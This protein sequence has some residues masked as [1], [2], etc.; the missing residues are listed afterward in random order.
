MTIIALDSKGHE[1]FPEPQVQKQA[2]RV[3]RSAADKAQARLDRIEQQMIEAK[4]KV[5]LARLSDCLE[6]LQK[7]YNCLCVGDTVHDED[8]LR[9]IASLT[10]EVAK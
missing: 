6:H 8:I 1:E 4:R 5:Q 10:A 3:R 9:I 2:K 7:A